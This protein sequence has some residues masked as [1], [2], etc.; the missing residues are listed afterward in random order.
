MKL[1]LD[2]CVWGGAQAAL[3]AAGHDV[4][5]CGSWLEE[6]GDA[7]ILA[8]AYEEGRVLVTLDKDSGELAIVHQQPPCGL[9]R[10]V[11]VGAREQGPFC[12][13]LIEHYGDDLRAGAIL[14]AEPS[15]VRIRPGD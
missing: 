3:R 10:L 5:W 9:I 14:T 1:P 12:A 4:T 6:P 2:S 15:R 7:Q 13:H 11:G 8:R